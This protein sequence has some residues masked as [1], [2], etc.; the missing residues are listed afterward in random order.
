MKTNGAGDAA[1]RASRLEKAVAAGAARLRLEAA[2]TPKGPWSAL[3]ELRLI[4]PLDSA[5]SAA[6]VD[7]AALQFSPFRDGRGLTPR[8]LVH[9]LRRAVYAASQTLRPH[10]S[11]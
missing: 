9:G 2:T 10:E 6:E 3:A 4:E 5:D 11:T 1:D 7:Q 8:G